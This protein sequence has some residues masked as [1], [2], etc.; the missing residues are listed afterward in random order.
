MPA[1]VAPQP[2]SK[3]AVF[4]AFSIVAALT[5]FTLALILRVGLLLFGIT[6]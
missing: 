3:L 2:A 4:F 1:K 5:L 6:L